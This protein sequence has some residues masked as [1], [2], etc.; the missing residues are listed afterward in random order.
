MHTLHIVMYS[1][2]CM[3][4]C[5]ISRPIRQNGDRLGGGGRQGWGRGKG[6]T[7][8][9]LHEHHVVGV[10]RVGVGDVGTLIFLFTV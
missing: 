1:T 2:W 5:K 6:L 8:N 9:T 10:D 7:N 4:V 3:E